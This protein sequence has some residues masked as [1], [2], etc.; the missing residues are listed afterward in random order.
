MKKVSAIK[1]DINK[2]YYEMI[3]SEVLRFGLNELEESQYKA[4]NRVFCASGSNKP[5]STVIWYF[6]LN[7]IKT[8]FNKKS[9]KLP[10]VLDSPKNAEMDYNKEQALIE[11]ILENSSNYTQLIFSSIGFER[12]KFEGKVKII[13]LKNNK[14]QLLDSETFTKYEN[15]LENVLSTH[16]HRD[17]FSE[18]I[19]L[20]RK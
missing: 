15:I 17:I 10:M 8:C 11:Y 2:K 3:D 5:I 4:I 14:Y 18:L 19:K 16:V 1:A 20:L 7:N 13:E 6:I 12:T 9:L